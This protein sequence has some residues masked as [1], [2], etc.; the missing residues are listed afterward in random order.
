MSKSHTIN[1]KD[2]PEQNY[3]ILIG[4]DMLPKVLAYLNEYGFAG[5]QAIVTDGNEISS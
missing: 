4:H 3:D 1:F 5:R 2:T